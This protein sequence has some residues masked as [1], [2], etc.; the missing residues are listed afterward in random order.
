[1][2]GL[3]ASF[4][5]GDETMKKAVNL[6]Q[7]YNSGFHIHVAEGKYDQEHCQN[8]HNKSVIERLNNFGALDSSKSILVH[9]LHLNDKER[10]LVSQSKAYIVQNME[11]NLNNNVG[12]FNSKGLGKN[13]MLGTDGMHSDMLQSAKSAFFVGQGFDTIDFSSVYERFRKV[14]EYIALNQFDGDG[15]NNLVILDYDSPTPINQ[16]NFLGHF[17]FG[18]N[19]N[20]INDVISNGKIIVK[21]RK[22]Q[23]VNE[24][25]ILEFSKEQSVRLWKKMKN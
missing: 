15:E 9:C 18:I 17:V 3:H 20:H 25:E 4:T 8:H 6:M 10:K 7:K 21:G 12:Y 24:S 1:L 13:I 23:T 19:S 22:M 14:H 2:V 5:V 16:D 11:S